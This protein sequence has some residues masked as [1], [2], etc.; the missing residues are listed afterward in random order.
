MS[1]DTSLSSIESTESTESTV[2][3]G[4]ISA[5]ADQSILSE[6]VESKETPAE[7]TVSE[8]VEPKGTESTESAAI[9]EYKAIAPNAQVRFKTQEDGTLLLLLPNESSSND[10]NTTTHATWTEILQQIRQRLNAGGRFWQPD[11]SVHLIAQDRLL[12]GRQ[13]QAIAE[14]L[15]ES[16]LK[17]ERI[18]TSRRQTAVAAV[19]AGYSVEQRTTVTPFNPN[20]VATVQALADPL[21]LET[22]LRSGVEIRHPGNVIL[23]GDVNPG[24]SIIADGDILVWGRLRG[25]AQ[26]GANGN[27]QCIVMALQMEPTQIRIADW[28]ARSPEPLPEFYPEVAYVSPEGIRIAKAAD[29]SKAQ[30]ELKS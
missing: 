25:L 15:G 18:E 6:Q 17:L 27:E 29:F 1:S 22:T 3:E 23:V 16:K 21:Y 5:N 24:G 20:P 12:D 26:A 14:A 28:V 2:S 9:S 13:L 10:A 30:L 11:T 8:Q 7:S 19:T 4:D